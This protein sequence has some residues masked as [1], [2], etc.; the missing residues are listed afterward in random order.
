MKKYIKYILLTLI[1]FIVI[2][3]TSNDDSLFYKNSYAYEIRESIENKDDFVFIISA[4]TCSHCEEFKPIAEA[5]ANELNVLVVYTDYDLDKMDD[6]RNLF[7]DYELDIQGTPTSF[8]V[9]DGQL[10]HKIEGSISEDEFT[11]IL[12]NYF[13]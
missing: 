10:V 9:I 2:G 11:L 3:C 6:I 4:S 5:V 12:N 13:N 1:S 7:T 8:V